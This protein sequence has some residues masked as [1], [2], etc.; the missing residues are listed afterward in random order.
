MTKQEKQA[1][2]KRGIAHCAALIRQAQD[3]ALSDGDDTAAGAFELLVASITLLRAIQPDKSVEMLM[4][5]SMG[6]AVQA[7]HD[8]FKLVTPEVAD[9]FFERVSKGLQ[10]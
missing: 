1:A 6:A 10:G 5:V 2:A 7:S 9:A 4:M 8:F 3:Q